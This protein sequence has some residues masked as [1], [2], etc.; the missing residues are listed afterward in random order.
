VL[1]VPGQAMIWYGVSKDGDIVD[2]HYF[3][4][5]HHCNDCNTWVDIREQIEAED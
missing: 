3:I 4:G 5:N 2:A 1:N